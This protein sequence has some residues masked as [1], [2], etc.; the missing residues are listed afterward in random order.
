MQYFSQGLQYSTKACLQVNWHIWTSILKTKIALYP[1]P[2][3]ASRIR[4]QIF[5]IIN[6]FL[7]ISFFGQYP[8]NILLTSNF[9][10][11]V[12]WD[13][14]FIIAILLMELRF[15]I[16]YGIYAS[17]QVRVFRW[18]NCLC[19]ITLISC[20]TQTLRRDIRYSVEQL[21]FLHILVVSCE[22]W[23]LEQ[24]SN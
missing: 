23:S 9:S 21:Y 22:H 11:L 14:W 10:L 18:Q 6:L 24:V 4:A 16:D 19:L 2:I 20:I 17:L 3:L 8:I 12:D 13:F 15:L 5:T 7:M 1:R